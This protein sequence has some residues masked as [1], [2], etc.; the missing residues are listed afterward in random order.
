MSVSYRTHNASY[1]QTV[2][3]IVNE[4]QDSKDDRCK[5]CTY[6][7]VDLFAGPSSECGRAAGLVHHTYHR[8]Q[9]NQEDQDSYVIAVR[10]NLDDSSLKNLC[11][12]SFEFESGIKQCS[13]YNSHKQRTVYFFCDQRKDDRYKRW[14][15]CPD[16]C[17]QSRLISLLR[18]RSQHSQGTCQCAHE[19]HCHNRQCCSCF[20]THF[21]PPFSG[22]KK[23]R[24]SLLRTP[25]VK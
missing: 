11:Y 20:F 7:C 8:S 9:D 17:I 16:C 4:D 24:L 10:K 2:K 6:T 21:S 5:L 18:I 25:P 23:R 19:Y 12:G 1:C 15:Q 13:Y 22:T 14:K 3:I